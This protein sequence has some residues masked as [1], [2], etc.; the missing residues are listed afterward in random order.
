MKLPALRMPW[1]AVKWTPLLCWRLGLAGVVLVCAGVL[2]YVWFSGASETHYA[3]SEGRRLVLSPKSGIL[4]GKKNETN[5][6]PTP[7][8]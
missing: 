3:L 2:L 1:K 5:A 8:S 6:A 4:E 7:E